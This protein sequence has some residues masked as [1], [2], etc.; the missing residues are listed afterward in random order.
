MDSPLSI[1]FK[2]YIG[3]ILFGAFVV[4]ALSHGISNDVK[5]AVIEKPQIETSA[6]I[7]APIGW[8]EQSWEEQKK[9]V[10]TNE[11]AGRR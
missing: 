5:T 11:P 9:L 2:M 4:Y 3:L 6:K 1:G 7:P 10:N 8:D